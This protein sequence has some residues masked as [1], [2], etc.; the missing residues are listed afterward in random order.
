MRNFLIVLAIAL[1]ACTS[2]NH[3]ESQRR[4]Q[5][6]YMAKVQA[7]ELALATARSA[8]SGDLATAM[9][10]ENANV[11]STEAARLALARDAERDLDAVKGQFSGAADE[12]RISALFRAALKAWHAGR[13]ADPGLVTE[14][15]DLG[16]KTCAGLNDRRP[17]RDCQILGLAR[18]LSV[19]QTAADTI[20]D[21]LVKRLS[22]PEQKLP[23]SDLAD[24]VYSI[25]DIDNATG[26]IAEQAPNLAGPVRKFAEGQIILYWCHAVSGINQTFELE[27]R[28]LG[29]KARELLNA[30]RG[31]AP[32]PGDAL[33]AALTRNGVFDKRFIGSNTSLEEQV[34]KLDANL[35]GG[36][37][38]ANTRT[39]RRLAELKPPDT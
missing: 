7:E 14:I 4:L 31:S 13:A 21:L 18:D 20:F 15:S 35:V 17:E 1:S 30:D 32:A 25:D 27:D 5:D 28:D 29:R 19:A 33:A 11:S 26:K 6:G 12:D 2:V 8:S 38:D 22:A 16:G 34:S 37:Q 36:D 9:T 10:A 23:T 24:L 39:C 3:I